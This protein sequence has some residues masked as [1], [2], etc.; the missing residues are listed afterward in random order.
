MGNF[1]LESLDRKLTAR[2]LLKIQHQDEQLCN[3]HGNE[4]LQEK[5]TSEFIQ[6]F[7]FEVLMKN[8]FHV[9]IPSL[10]EEFVRK[11]DYPLD[12]KMK[13]LREKIL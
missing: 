10:N 11:I 1:S 9:N 12:S 6:Y 8:C 5:S 7:F 3:P 13:I 2:R 4:F